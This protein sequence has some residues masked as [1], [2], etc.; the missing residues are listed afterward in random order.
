MKQAELLFTMAVVGLAGLSASFFAPMDG[1][2]EI[3]TLRLMYLAFLLAG[4]FGT[5]YVLRG[6]KY[7]VLR[8][9]FEENNMAAALVVAAIFIAVAMVIGR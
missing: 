8:E 6:T 7:D 5:M 4:A 1:V 2:L 9:V 3:I